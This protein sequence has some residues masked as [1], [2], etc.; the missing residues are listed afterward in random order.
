MVDA[1]SMWKDPLLRSPVPQIPARSRLIV[2]TTGDFD[3]RA[4]AA[5]PVAISSPVYP[6]RACCKHR[7]IVGTI[8]GISGS[9]AGGRVVSDDSVIHPNGR[10]HSVN[11]D[12]VLPLPVLR[13]YAGINLED[14][15]IMSVGDSV[16]V[17]AHST[18]NACRL[19]MTQ[20]D[21]DAYGRLMGR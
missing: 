9:Q 12:C 16:D 10:S 17:W 19:P 2:P 14:G 7:P 18:W 20:A 21:V 6:E 5:T 15:A 3:S 1:R 8:S 13:E 11:P 4:K